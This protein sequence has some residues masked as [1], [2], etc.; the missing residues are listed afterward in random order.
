MVVL[1]TAVHFFIYLE[2]L[3]NDSHSHFFVLEPPAI[4]KQ[5]KIMKIKAS[6][7]RQQFSQD[8]CCTSDENKVYA[9]TCNWG[10]AQASSR[11]ED[12]ALEVLLVA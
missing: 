6:H 2:D 4:L 3:S 8:R 7:E 10:G 1:P 9:V 11:Q 12:K 5:D